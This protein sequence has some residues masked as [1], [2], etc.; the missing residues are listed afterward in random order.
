MCTP[1]AQTA[2]LC[3][4]RVTDTVRLRLSTYICARV[5][6]TFRVLKNQSLKWPISLNKSW[7]TG[8]WECEDGRK[9]NWWETGTG[10][11]ELLRVT[12]GVFWLVSCSHPLR[13]CETRGS[14]A[15][16]CIKFSRDAAK[17]VIFVY[18]RDHEAFCSLCLFD[19]K[20][21]LSSFWGR[22]RTTAVGAAVNGPEFVSADNLLS[23][24][25][26]VLSSSC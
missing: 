12:V 11:S 20:R 2:I 9:A 7:N 13:L 23:D 17:W 25:W 22:Y 5:N 10:G 16:T 24:P 18:S 6:V 4:I 14:N 8:E 15:S 19:P 21:K 1:E 26:A 3:S